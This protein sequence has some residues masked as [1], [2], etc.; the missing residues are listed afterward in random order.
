[1]SL[2]PFIL[3]GCGGS[4]V[5]SVRH[6]RDEV[7]ARLRVHGIEKIPAAWQ[8]IG[9]DVLPKMSELGEASPLPPLDYVQMRVGAKNLVEVEE[10]L[11]AANPP[12]QRGGYTEL[13]GWRPSAEDLSAVNPI[14]GMTNRGV[15]RFVGA[16]GLQGSAIKSRLESA[17]TACAAGG[18]ELAAVAQEM[19]LPVANAG[20][21]DTHVI[22]ITSMAGGCGAGISLDVI[23]LLRKWGGSA[24]MPT[25]IAYGADIFGASNRRDY[26]TAN[27]LAYLS[28]LLN[29][30]W[31]DDGGKHLLFPSNKSKPI[32]RGPRAAFFLGRKNLKGFDFQDSR[33]VYR[34]AGVTIAGIILNPA[35][36]TR[37]E[38]TILGN[39]TIRPKGGYGFADSAIIGEVSSFGS[40][41]IAVGRKRFRDYARRYLLRDLYEHH[42]RG[43]KKVALSLFGEDG[44]KATDVAIKARLVTKFLP[45]VIEAYGL[46][47]PF[48]EKGAILDDGSAQISDQL[49]SA[50]HIS[51]FA[52]EVSESILARLPNESLSGSEWS[53]LVAAELAVE[54]RRLLMDA[55]ARFQTREED[56][57]NGIAGQNGLVHKVMSVSNDYLTRLSLPVMIDLSQGVIES[58]NRTASQ[59][60]N[61]ATEALAKSK[62]FAEDSR[63]EFADVSSNKLSK[64]SPQIQSAVEY[65]AASVGQELKAQISNSI[66]QTL[67]QV[68]I[69]LL[70]P[71]N[72]AFRRAKDDV[73]R[74]AD[75]TTAGEAPV[76]HQWPVDSVVPRAFIPSSIEH[77][78]EGHEDW[79]RTIDRLLRRAETV[80]VGESTIDAVRRGISDGIATGTAIGPNDIRPLLWTR[81]DAPIQFARTAPLAI[82]IGLDLDALEERVDRWLG[83]PGR[84]LG[85]F[86]R[87]GLGEYLRDENH[88]DHNQ[89]MR[90]FEEKLRMALEQANPFVETDNVYFRTTYKSL[91]DKPRLIYLVEPIPFP[92]GHKAHKVTRDMLLQTVGDAG[93]TLKFEPQDREGFTVSTFFEAP[94]FPGI[95]SSIMKEIAEVG[96]KFV[97]KGSSELRDWLDFKRGRTLDEFIP[98]P[99]KVTR[100]LIRGFVVGRLTGLLKVPASTSL[101]YE[102]SSEDEVLAFPHP[103]YG[104]VQNELVS[105]LMSFPLCFI[106]VS[107]ER[108]E[109]FAAYAALFRLGMSDPS[110]DLAP[111][112]FKLAGELKSLL[113]N[114]RTTLKQIDTPRAS[115][116]SREERL[117][118]AVAYVEKFRDW[119]EKIEARPYTGEERV[120]LQVTWEDDTVPIKEIAKLLLE[121]YGNVLNALTG[122]GDDGP[123]ET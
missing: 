47:N 93:P 28:E 79:P 73:F 102:I 92:D 121:E 104:N 54:K 7:R 29:A 21:M 82:D 13:V 119:L 2:S 84:E 111:S 76:I 22:V 25:L 112:R 100:A 105:I 122:E 81:N 96:G 19:G 12:A 99:A 1:M 89:R 40:A 59:F 66:A 24:V 48:G 85:D 114:G 60:K 42:F 61:S 18:A 37:F 26:W 117:T 63:N 49:L 113:D 94:M 71:L 86:L 88:P 55:T 118:N 39:W 11:L 62:L 72:A 32:K 34:A 35:V 50:R 78:L 83:K 9:I 38:E 16:S 97:N 90:K 51:G 115:G 64:T 107:R 52:T 43:Y 98:L 68:V 17:L 108:E 10:I 15:G 45:E 74:L 123:P 58:V 67:E 87:E 46:N 103:A 95:I 106:N 14:A 101:P 31:S 3:V 57:L 69:N 5:L 70:G 65:L 4:G 30:M 20:T 116:G 109:A 33:T 23:D 53:E 8:F 75:V 91:D 41:T 6:V 77:L 36:L 56:W 80:N 110:G 44:A 120:R 27:N